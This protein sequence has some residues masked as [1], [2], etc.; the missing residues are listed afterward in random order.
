MDSKFFKLLKE[1]RESG[2][3][4]Q[5]VYLYVGTFVRIGTEDVKVERDGFIADIDKYIDTVSLMDFEN[6][7][8]KRDEFESNNSVI[9]LND[10]EITK[11][12][13]KT[14]E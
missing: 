11:N 13:I 8:S 2:L 1:C 6:P 3:V 4:G 14:L 9:M 5:R 10:E 7:V 12:V